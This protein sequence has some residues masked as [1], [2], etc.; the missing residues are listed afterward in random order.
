MFLFVCLFMFVTFSIIF[1]IIQ[2]NHTSLNLKTASQAFTSPQF[3]K[4]NNILLSVSPNW[5]REKLK[6][7]IC[8]GKGRGHRG[9]PLGSIIQ[10]WPGCYGCQ[11]GNFI[12]LYSLV[13]Y[14][15]GQ[16]GMRAHWNEMQRCRSTHSKRWMSVRT[17]PG[18]TV[19]IPINH[20]HQAPSPSLEKSGVV[21][22]S[23]KY[24]KPWTGGWDKV[25]VPNFLGLCTPKH[26]VI[27]FQQ[28]RCINLNWYQ[29]PTGMSTPSLIGVH[30]SPKVDHDTTDSEMKI[31][32]FWFLNLNI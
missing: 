7:P 5:A 15:V 32:L 26:F 21:Q 17:C 14:S 22:H 29:M 28:A 6:K 8:A 27:P 3:T 23:T 13:L 4:I 18:W 9:I 20:R 10:G 11:V 24:P 2:I 12:I 16:N 1:N 19:Q 31:I 30:D 25:A